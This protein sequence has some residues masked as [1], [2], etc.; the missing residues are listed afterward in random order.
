M[1]HGYHLPLQRLLQREANLQALAALAALHQ[2]FLLRQL[3]PGLCI[4][5]ILPA[6]VLQGAGGGQLPRAQRRLPVHAALRRRAPDLHRAVCQHPVPGL[7]ADLHDGVRVGQ[8]APVR[9]PQPDGHLQLHRP[10]PPLGAAGLLRRAG[11]QPR[12]GPPRHGGRPRVLLPRGRLPADVQPAT[13]E[14]ARHPA[15]ALP[16]PANPADRDGWPPPHGLIPHVARAAASVASQEARRWDSCTDTHLTIGQRLAGAPAA[17]R[18]LC[19]AELWL[20]L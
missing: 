20:I 1:R 14:N 15:R 13:A 7:L 9:Q 11:Q 10:L 3:G 4:P 17:R 12:G 5:H 6:Q 8:A 19:M 18:P 16:P 2:L